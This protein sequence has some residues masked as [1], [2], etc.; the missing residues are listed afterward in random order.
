[1]FPLVK[2]EKLL[3]KIF[4]QFHPVTPFRH[5]EAFPPEGEARLTKY[6]IL[7][8]LTRLGNP[9]L[10]QD[11]RA[12]PKVMWVLVDAKERRFRGRAACMLIKAVASVSPTPGRE[13]PLPVTGFQQS[14]HSQAQKCDLR[15][16][17][18]LGPIHACVHQ[19]RHEW[20]HFF[21]LYHGTLK[22][23][24]DA[25]VTP[26]KTHIHTISSKTQNSRRHYLTHSVC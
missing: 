23:V 19:A 14:R 22:R 10:L 17:L 21:L 7:M 24:R 11:P 4:S 18:H 9:G 26:D 6:R 12:L 8:K 16:Q 3:G 15:R 5:I 13:L 2:P 20:D 1:M 25:Y